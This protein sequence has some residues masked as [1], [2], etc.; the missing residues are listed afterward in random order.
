MRT[1]H[2]MLL[3]HSIADVQFHELLLLLPSR[4]LFLLLLALLLVQLQLLLLLLPLLLLYETVSNLPD[5]DDTNH[6]LGL[7]DA[8]ISTEQDI[9]S[10]SSVL[11]ER[12][13]KIR[14]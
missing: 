1:R 12:K 9:H 7:I 10:L 13:L 6:I 11:E 2:N 8:R 4:L 3:Q 5:T 14:R